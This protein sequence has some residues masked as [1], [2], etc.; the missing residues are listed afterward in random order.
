MYVVSSVDHI[1]PKESITLAKTT[2]A[3]RLTSEVSVFCSVVQAGES[4]V[5]VRAL[6]TEARQ[7]ATAQAALPPD[8]P[9]RLQ[10]VQQQGLTAMVA[11]LMTAA[12]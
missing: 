12:G 4:A 1:H 2:K 3:P 11:D 7:L 9:S 10:D 8:H 5:P 6:L